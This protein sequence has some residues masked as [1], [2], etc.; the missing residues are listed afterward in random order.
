MP[1]NDSHKASTKSAGIPVE[2][3][4]NLLRWHEVQHHQGMVHHA[5]TNMQFGNLRALEA[6]IDQHKTRFFFRSGVAGSAKTE[7]SPET[8]VAIQTRT[9]SL[10][11]QLRECDLHQ[12]QQLR[13][14][15]ELTASYCGRLLWAAEEKNGEQVENTDTMREKIYNQRVEVRSNLQ[16]F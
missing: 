11:R 4:S 1:V 9:G 8:I 3:L 2:V 5:V 6:R 14:S 12:I 13:S 15:A 10:L 7:L 16:S